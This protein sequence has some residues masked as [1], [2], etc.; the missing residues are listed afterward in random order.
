MGNFKVKALAAILLPALAF[1][2][3]GA[4]QQMEEVVVTGSYIKSSP[5]DGASPVEVVSRSNIDE[6]AAMTISDIT[7][8]L[9]VNSGSEN[10]PDSFTSGASQGTS[11]VNLR[12][13]VLGSTLILVNGNCQR[14]F[15]LC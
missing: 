13:L 6:M 3:F 7:R 4:E 11:N 10:V 2:A 5:T 1:N 15:K 14:R 8:N 12:G 9:T